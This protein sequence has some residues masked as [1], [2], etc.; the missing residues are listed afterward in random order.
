MIVKG[1]KEKILIAG[2]K[3]W[4]ISPVEVIFF[5]LRARQSTKN[6]SG[7]TADHYKFGFDYGRHLEQNSFL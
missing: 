2:R 6:H 7:L 4:F 3:I 1:M 5:A